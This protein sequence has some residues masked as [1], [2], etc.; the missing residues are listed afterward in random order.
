MSTTERTEH[1]GTAPVLGASAGRDVLG[2]RRRTSAISTGKRITPQPADLI[3]FGK[4]L[5]HGPLPSSYLLAFTRHLRQSDKRATERLTD[6]FNEAETR[7]GGRYLERPPQQFRTLD[8]R[9]NQLVYD[10]AA[11]ALKALREAGETPEG[12]A[13]PG[14]PWLHRFMVACVTASVELATLQRADLSY[15]AQHRIL[16]RA[17]AELRCPVAIEYPAAGRPITRDLIPDAIL[18]LEYK[19]EAGSR[20]RFF[21]VECDRATEPAMS[22]NFNRKSWQ[23]SLLQYREYIGAKRYREHLK[24]TAPLLVLNVTTDA[25]R[26]AKMLQIAEDHAGSDGVSY[27]LFQVVDDFGPVFRPPSPMPQLLEAPWQRP[28][29]S[30]FRIDQA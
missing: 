27:Q 4:L 15:I 10:L 1:R 16:A 11:P 17:G 5:E 28:G 8:S 23:R 9:Y 29:Q 19:T 21:V 30:R 18:G 2:R 20:F 7:H 22:A 6:L 12:I 24:L 25:K 13:R 26:Q 3:W 14:G